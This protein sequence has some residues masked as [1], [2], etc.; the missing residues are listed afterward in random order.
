MRLGAAALILTALASAPAMADNLT[1]RDGAPDRY[2]VREGDTL[3][4]I[5]EHFLADPWRWPAI[6]KVNNQIENPHLIY[7]GDVIVVSHDAN[8]NPSLRV[9][10]NQRFT[11]KTVKLSPGIY[12][13]SLEKAIPTIPPNIIQPFLTRPLVV[14]KEDLDD[15]GYVTQGVEDNIILGAMQQFYARN[16]QN[17]DEE[18]FQVYRP[19]KEMRDP[20]SNEVLGWEAIYV[21]DARMLRYDADVSKLEITHSAEETSP[22]DR[23]REAP[24]RDTLPY[25]F[26]TPPK[27]DVQGR[28]MKSHNGV[29]EMGTYSIVAINLGE[30][31]GMQ[32]GH[33][34]R[35]KRKTRTRRDPVT[36][37]EYETPLENSGLVMIFRVF[38]RVSYALV[39]K[40]TRA[41]HVGDVV[42]TP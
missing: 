34:L 23:L 6:W 18:V 10:R 42:V 24:T 13:D 19:G 1:L 12:V 21:A 30:S 40:S 22:G 25:Y 38:D 15:D 35:V 41:L 7:P 36:L 33:V 17:A 14:S 32:T 26:P 8:G 37:R 29:A 2:T 27:Q 4:G 39:M 16:V 11:G 9:L 3:W 5:A 31:D 28:I 20:D